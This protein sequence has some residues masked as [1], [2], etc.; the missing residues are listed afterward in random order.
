MPMLVVVTMHEA[1]EPGAGGIESG[2][3]K[4]RDFRTVVRGPEQGLGVWIVVADARA[5]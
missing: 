2:E 4:V 1:R 3:A 5:L